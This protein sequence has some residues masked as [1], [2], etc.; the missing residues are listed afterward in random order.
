MYHL[1]FLRLIELFPFRR[2]YS[3]SFLLPHCLWQFVGRGMG[4]GFGSQEAA[5]STTHRELRR[6][7]AGSEAT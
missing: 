4:G 7:T 1:P 3:G 5:K 2:N 6:G